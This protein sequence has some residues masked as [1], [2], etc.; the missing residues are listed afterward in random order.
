V[1]AIERSAITGLILAGGRGRRL[2]S[3]DKG[4]ALWQGRPL[5]EH[6]LGRLTPQVGAVLISANR[7]RERYG[8]LGCSV[9][10]DADE[11]FSGPLA[12]MLAGLR[13]ARTEWLAVVPCDAPQLPHDL[14]A[15]L[16]AGMGGA[17][18]AVATVD[19]RSQPVFCL[20]KTSLADRLA[21]DLSAGLHAT[22]RWLASIGAATVAFADARAFA[23]LN[24]AE[25]F[26][27]AAA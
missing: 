24:T 9:V 2:G 17:A 26:A 3:V 27:A 4:L 7:N 23:N 22:G 14:V 21:A 19:G 25:D 12:G 20:L 18:A 11:S 6:A 1:A 15:R 8:A 5:V 10:A 16:T 13:A